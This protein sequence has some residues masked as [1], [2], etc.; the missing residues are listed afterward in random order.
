MPTGNHMKKAFPVLLLLLAMLSACALPVAGTPHA[1]TMTPATPVPTAGPSLTPTI[2]ATATP[3]SNESILLGDRAL[4]NGDYS[5]AVT[6]YNAALAAGAEGERAAFFLSRALFL[7]GDAKGARE[8]LENLIANHPAGEYTARANFLLGDVAAAQEDWTA[9][10]SAYQNFLLQMPGILTDFVQERVGDSLLAGGWSDQAVQAYAAAADASD[11]ANRLRLLEKEADT[12]S[13]AR[14]A[15]PAIALYE[16]VL[17]GVSSTYAKARLQRKI[18]GALIALGRTEEGYAR[19]EAALQYPASHDAFLCLSEL[20]YAGYSVD[21]LTR[22]IIDY[23]EGVYDTALAVLSDYLAGNPD[24]PAKAH[25]FRGLAARASDQPQ[26][27]AADFDAAAALGPE[28][29]FWDLALFE[30]AYTRWAWLGDYAGAVQILT[31]LADAM[32]AHPRAAEA[33]FTAARVAERGGDLALAAQLWMRMADAYP[34]DSPAR[35]TPGRRAPPPETDGPARRRCSGRPRRA[36]SAANPGPRRLSS[37]RPRP[38]R[39]PI[40]TP[41]AHPTSSPERKPS[42]ATTRST[43][44]ST[45]TPSTARPKPGCNRSSRRSCRWSSATPS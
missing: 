2:L 19:Y 34:A 24:E 7:S 35:R 20:L 26:D 14:L 4:L 12:L 41:S 23:Y 39:R 45:S 31:G 11:P 40:T 32:P 27:A 10:V 29:G 3:S 43:S 15:E 1:A 17:A 9:S 42:P 5:A 13:G 6:Y 22:G 18:G 37:S 8:V 28:T 30:G 25:Y 38:L 36:S 44:S 33:L 21:N 16:E